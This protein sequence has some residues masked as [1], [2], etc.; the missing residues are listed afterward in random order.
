MS[1]NMIDAQT[2][3]NAENP[4]SKQKLPKKVHVKGWR[5]KDSAKREIDENLLNLL[6]STKHTMKEFYDMVKPQCPTC[7][8]NDTR[9][10]GTR[11]SYL[12]G[13]RVVYKCLNPD[14]QRQEFVIDD[15]RINNLAIKNAALQMLYFGGKDMAPLAKKIITQYGVNYTNM[16]LYEHVRGLTKNNAD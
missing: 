13:T 11:Q 6:D 2:Q 10:S 5:P 9:E 8:K 16:P 3:N 15:S 12:C 7:N 4:S 1:K 14:C